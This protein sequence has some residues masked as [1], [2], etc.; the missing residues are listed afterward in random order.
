MVSGSRLPGPGKAGAA[1]CCT[2]WVSS[3]AISSRPASVV[4]QIAIG[5]ESDVAS[6]GI[7]NGTE[8]AG[9]RGAD[10]IVMDADRGKVVAEARRK[11]GLQRGVERP[12]GSSGQIGRRRRHDRD[13]AGG[14]CRVRQA[15]ALRRGR[16]QARLRRSRSRRRGPPRAPAPPSPARGRI[17]SRRP[18]CPATCHPRRWRP[19]SA[20]PDATK[21]TL[22]QPACC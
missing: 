8:R 6:N 10:A 7:G 13:R 14:T 12:S 19:S 2:T 9:R 17:S 5:V 16:L 20:L 21:R 4:R 11:I 3:C 1:R 18:D 22:K 15:L